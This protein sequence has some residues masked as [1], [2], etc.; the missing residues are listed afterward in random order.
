MA[1]LAPS[2]LDRI[3]SQAN[4]AGVS[5]AKNLTSRTPLETIRNRL[6]DKYANFLLALEEEFRASIPY[7][8]AYN[9]QATVGGL[10]RF[11]DAR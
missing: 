1:T 11:L 2:I 4:F 9:D 7:E 5:L 8:V 6:G 3:R 10:V